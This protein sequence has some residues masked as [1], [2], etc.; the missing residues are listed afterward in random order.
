MAER[1]EKAYPNR[2]LALLHQLARN[3]VNRG[4]VV[5]IN[6]MPEA[7]A[8]SEQRGAEQ[9]RIAVKRRERPGPGEQIG[10]G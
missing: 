8:V 3:I 1:E 2:S 4:N 5:G 10:R 6:C 9:Q 7:K